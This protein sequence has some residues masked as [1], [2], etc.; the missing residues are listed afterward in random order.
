MWGAEGRATM[1]RWVLACSLA[2]L[3]GANAGC[4][5]ASRADASA[6]RI[7]APDDTAGMLV[8]YVVEH[9]LDE[10]AQRVFL[11]SQELRDCCGTKSQTALAA[12]DIELAVLCPAAADEL[13]ARD[14]RFV[15][16]GAVAANTDVVVVRR[17]P[18]ARVGIT[19]NRAYQSDVVSDV[20]DDETEAVPM[21]TESLPY[22][23]ENGEVDAIVTDFLR[24]RSVEGA[25]MPSA[26]R[27]GTRRVTYVLVST[28]EFERDA[29][30]GAVI[31]EFD[32]AARALSD[33]AKLVQQVG[34]YTGVPMSDEEVSEWR[35]LGV[36]LLTVSETRR[37]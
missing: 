37:S 1:R 35:R 9:G 26:H 22:A 18:P 7:G 34:E 23:L 12:G 33:S 15:V 5:L 3:I 6:V 31:E 8:D 19:Q 11:E 36:R 20:F 13:I 4:S 16:V 2:L 29:R 14:P 24:A 27:D 25:R 17:D 21:L 30:F 10:R 28:R 32:A